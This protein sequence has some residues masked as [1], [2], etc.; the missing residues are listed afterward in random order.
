MA[1]YIVDQMYLVHSPALGKLSV[2]HEHVVALEVLCHAGNVQRLPDKVSHRVA[3]LFFGLY[4]ADKSGLIPWHSL[5]LH[6]PASACRSC[7]QL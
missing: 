5:S 1:L 2:R 6:M 7:L 3:F 4:I